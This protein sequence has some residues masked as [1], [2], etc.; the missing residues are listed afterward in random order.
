MM[1][2]VHYITHSLLYRNLHLAHVADDAH[3]LA[4]AVVAGLLA[5]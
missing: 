1:N 2:R 5:D 3:D 4:A